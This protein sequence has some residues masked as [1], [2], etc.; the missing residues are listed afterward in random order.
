M[1]AV[2]CNVLISCGSAKIEE[3]SIEEK[4][5]ELTINRTGEEDVLKLLSLINS[6]KLSINKTTSQELSELFKIDENAYY[7]N[8]KLTLEDHTLYI[9]F[10][11]SSGVI[12]K[13]SYA[14]LS[15]SPKNFSYIDHL[16]TE[17]YGNEYS[18]TYNTID[19]LDNNALKVWDLDSLTVLYESFS[20]L[21]SGYEI[22]IK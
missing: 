1:F 21:N 14:T 3:Q 2:I 15:N 10:T 8:K 11:I 16:L 22:I 9:N 13:I 18:I 12:S 5:E 7:M 17:E 4:S 19:S 6:G 20:D